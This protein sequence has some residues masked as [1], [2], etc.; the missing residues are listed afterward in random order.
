MRLCDHIWAL[1]F[2]IFII[3]I[4]YSNTLNN[5]F[6][7]D[8]EHSIENNKKI[9]ITH[10]SALLTRDVVFNNVVTL[11]NRP[12]SSITFA[13][14]YYFGK[15]DV[16]G[17]HL[18]NIIIHIITAITIYL[19]LYITLDI[20]NEFHGK[21]TFWIAI[22]ATLLWATSPVQT[23]AVTYI[24]QRVTSL[25]TMF[26]MLSLLCFVKWRLMSRDR[27]DAVE[28]GIN[29][30]I[31]PKLKV[32]GWGIFSF[33]STYFFLMIFFSFMAFGSKEVSATLPLIII[34]YEIYFIK[35]FN[36]KEVKKISIFLCL[37]FLF[38]IIIGLIYLSIGI[39]GEILE[40]IK[41]HLIERQDDEKIYTTIERL[42][43]E[44]RIII[45]Y[46]SLLIL[47]LPSRLRT[48][49]DFSISHSL[50]NPITT[51][52]SLLM[53]LSALGYGIYIR[54]NK[55]VISFFILWYFINLFIESTIIRLWLIF[56]YRLYLPSIGFYVIAAILI[57]K[58]KETLIN[59]VKS[60]PYLYKH[61][62]RFIY[63]FIIV[64]VITLQSAWTYERNL[65]YKDSKSFWYDN[66]KKTPTSWFVNYNLGV[67][68]SD[69]GKIKEAIYYYKKALQINPTDV[70]TYIN[71]GYNLEQLGKV[72]EAIYYYKK[73]LQIN[74]DYAKAH[75]NLGNALFET[76]KVDK[77][78]YYYKKAL[79]INPD[80]AKAHNNLGN[81]LLE[82]G[83]VDE[84]IYYYKKALQINPD[85]AEA[86]NNLGNA[87]FETG[88][89]DKAIYYYKKALQINPDFEEAYANIGVIL[90]SQG[91]RDKAIYYYKKALQ[92]N[93][94]FEGVKKKLDIVLEISRK[95]R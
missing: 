25:A 74:P 39:K 68:L 16:L 77:A 73:A 70:S 48:I 41:F 31:N 45:Y 53:I 15:L 38:F 91:E 42:F 32:T 65:I 64:L 37:L 63:L 57:V 13:I 14:N 1:T 71:F 24:I 66:F 52:I 30:L 5:K 18:V 93:P 84:A 12:V 69:L 59:K 87:L 36:K 17:Y 49:Y 26:Y 34:L 58:I 61:L 85:Y 92:I 35:R 7:L 8:D 55:K 22:I 10:L 67:T 3:V 83:K 51:T 2:I 28:T 6:V 95:S 47:P 94:D 33:T 82:T 54:K 21:K 60:F 88:K 56:E 62:F 9:H 46:I 44:F 75:N 27:C 89:V 78:I 43:T 19:F 76:G 20:S 80:Y 40:G 50:F 79:Q 90:E 23:Q 72:D 29:S 81:A 86:Y 11:T 4:I